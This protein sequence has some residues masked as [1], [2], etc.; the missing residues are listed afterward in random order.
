MLR[1]STRKA[2][3]LRAV[4]LRTSPL[5]GVGTHT[6]RGVGISRARPSSTA[7][8]RSPHI[9]EGRRRRHH[10]PQRTLTRIVGR[11][12]YA[13]SSICSR[14]AVHTA[15]LAAAGRHKDKHKEGLRKLV[16]TGSGRVPKSRRHQRGR[17]SIVDATAAVP[18][19]RQPAATKALPAT[20]SLMAAAPRK[21]EARGRERGRLGEGGTTTTR[22]EF[23]PPRRRRL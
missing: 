16:R 1:A 20:A 14:A 22:V 21:A 11:W 9:W 2:V 19:R 3:T 13:M 10:R 7:A 15:G 17:R 12:A 6:V 4:A 5:R 8:A 18:Q 23:I